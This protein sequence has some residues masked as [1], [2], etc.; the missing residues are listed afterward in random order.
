MNTLKNKNRRYKDLQSVYWALNTLKEN[1][2]EN[3]ALATGLKKRR[4]LSL[5]P[6][7]GSGYIEISSKISGLCK[8]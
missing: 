8:Q 7:I 6:S 4:V 5:Y 2:P 3:I 1:S